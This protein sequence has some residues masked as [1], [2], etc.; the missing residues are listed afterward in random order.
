MRAAVI[1]EPG[2]PEALRYSE[3]ADPECGP[4]DVRIGVRAA[5]VNWGDLFMRAGAGSRSYP[6]IV[7]W[8]I[9]GEI[10]SV[11]ANVDDRKVGERVVSLI[12]QGAYAELAT[13]PSRAAVPIPDNVTFD[14]A[15]ALPVTYLVSWYSLRQRAQVEPR[16]VVLITAGASGIGVAAIQIAKNMGGTVITTVGSDEKVEFCKRLGADYAINYNKQDFVEEVRSITDNR[17][18]DVVLEVVGGDVLVKS[19]DLLA[20]FGRMVSVGNSSNQ[21]AMINATST[22]FSGKRCRIEGFLVLVQPDIPEE[23]AKLVHEVS[24]GAIKAIIDKTFP[25]S[26]AP[27]AHRYVEERRNMGKVILNP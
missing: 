27:E 10:E 5:S 1:Y 4:N 22:F 21:T 12:P 8:D 15:G 19:V 2:G 25:L 11:G 23:M 16:E 14:E 6:F 26:E 17:G 18:V 7:G 20:R 9:A 24:R 13:A 3:I